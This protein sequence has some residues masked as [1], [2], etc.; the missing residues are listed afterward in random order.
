MNGLQFPMVI[1]DEC[2]QLLEPL[3]L[4]SIAPFGVEKLL[5]VGDPQQLPPPLTFNYG[6]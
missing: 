5:L 6:T 2:S 3:G 4:L 1:L